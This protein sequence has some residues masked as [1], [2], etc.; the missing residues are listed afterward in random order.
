MKSIFLLII[1]CM[2][3]CSL[4]Q[5]NISIPKEDRDNYEITKQTVKI[6]NI[7]EH[8]ILE[9]DNKKRGR[10]RKSNKNRRKSRNHSR[11]RSKSKAKEQ[12]GL[13]EG[14]ILLNSKQA[15]DIVTDLVNQA[16]NKGIDLPDSTDETITRIKRK[17]DGDVKYNW[18]FPIN[19]FVE[20]EVNSTVIDEALKLIEKHTCIRFQKNEKILNNASGLR[21]YFGPGCFSYV[22][23]MYNNKMQDVSIGQNCDTI[24][25]V[26]HETLHALGFDHEQCRYDR[27]DYIDIFLENVEQGSEN[28]FVKLSKEFAITLGTPYD[29]GSTMQYTY[30][31]F[32][33]DDKFT[34]LPKESLYNETLGLDEEA[35]FLDIKLLNKYYCSSICLNTLQCSN[36]GYQDPNDCS[37]CKCVEGFTGVQC[38][39]LPKVTETCKRVLF[40]V[41]NELQTLTLLGKKNCVYHFL[42]NEKEVILFYIDKARFLPRSYPQ[43]ILMNSLEVKYLDDK[44]RTGAIICGGK[45]DLKVKSKNYHLMLHYRSSED[46]NGAVVSFKSVKNSNLNYNIKKVADYKKN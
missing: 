3:K 16:E 23:R 46:D 21:Y 19:Y 33:K 36:G 8:E 38:D 42:S 11:R 28:N 13:F 1:F 14:D 34:M 44:T 6:V 45:V 7:I 29:Y 35:S 31:S 25:T 17:I 15:S 32:G 18:T 2:I 4:L 5:K 37:K 12:S 10:K 9:K 43:C 20:K 40:N 22:G 30:T 27:D 41:T 24:G 26:Q 39:E